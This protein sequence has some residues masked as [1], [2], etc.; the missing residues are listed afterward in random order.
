MRIYNLLTVL[1]NVVLLPIKDALEAGAMQFE[2][3]ATKLKRKHFCENIKVVSDVHLA[4][5]IG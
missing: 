3:T 4:L 1:L 5:F 2:T